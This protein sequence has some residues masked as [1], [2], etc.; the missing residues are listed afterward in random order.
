M[1]E[2]RL[3]LKSVGTE[4]LRGQT[5]SAAP[6]DQLRSLLGSLPISLIIILVDYDRDKP[7]LGCAPDFARGG[8]R[9]E[10]RDR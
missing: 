7:A 5:M 6:V 4:P 8:R 9:R 2:K 3:G 10:G 1:V